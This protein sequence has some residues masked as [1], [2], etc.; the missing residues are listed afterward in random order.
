[1]E[2]TI[3]VPSAVNETNISLYNNLKLV[4]NAISSV[5]GSEEL[6]NIETQLVDIEKQL[7]FLQKFSIN[8]RNQ[9]S[10]L[11]PHTHVWVREYDPCRTIYYCDICNISK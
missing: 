3:I 7:L 4:V 11:L 9:I 5:N 2:Q 1:M 10:K 8:T 6:K